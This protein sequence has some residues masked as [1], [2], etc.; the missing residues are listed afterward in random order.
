MAHGE[1]KNEKDKVI[2]E[3]RE[4]AGEIRQSREQEESSFITKRGLLKA[5]GTI[6]AG[7]AIFEGL[8]RSGALP[9]KESNPSRNGNSNGGREEFSGKAAIN[10]KTREKLA[11]PS[12]W[13][14]DHSLEDFSTLVDFKLSANRQIETV[15]V[16]VNGETITRL[17]PGSKKVAK[18]GFEI[19]VYALEAGENQI[20][21]TGNADGET[22]S[23]E[24]VKVEKNVPGLAKLDIH[25][26]RN[27]ELREKARE[28]E[29]D[30]LK[31]MY[32]EVMSN[33][34][35]DVTADQVESMLEKPAAA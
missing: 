15:D 20:E 13:G 24:Q 4:T 22:V 9:E 17:E 28:N 16:R 12:V 19:P 23:T 11:L 33:P 5:A 1:D 14:D 29:G 34:D 30:D 18:K 8:K 27:K 32:D 3:S 2:V 7:G 31:D 10:R 21:I 25:K 35:S 6:A 26:T